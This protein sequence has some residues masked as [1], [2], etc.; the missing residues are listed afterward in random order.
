MTEKELGSIISSAA[1]RVDKSMLRSIKKDIR[2]FLERFHENKYFVLM[3]MPSTDGNSTRYVTF[4]NINK[5]NKNVDVA[6][7]VYDFILDNE[8]YLGDL[9][10]FLMKD[11]YL[12]FWHGS[13]VYLF[14]P[15]DTGVE[16]IGY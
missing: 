7:E 2:V 9:K 1:P 4:F 16:E 15:Y 6:K 14:Y 13:E 12:E 11:D 3:G 5:E 10:G 8:K